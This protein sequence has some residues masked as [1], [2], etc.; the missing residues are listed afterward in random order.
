MDGLVKFQIHFRQRYF[1]TIIAPKLLDYYNKKISY[2]EYK[3][4][5]CFKQRCINCG[6]WYVTT[7]L[8]LCLNCKS[9]RCLDCPNEKC[10]YGTM[11]VVDTWGQRALCYDNH[12]V[13]FV[14]KIVRWYKRKYFK[15]HTIPNL[16]LLY[17]NEMKIKYHPNNIHKFIHF[18]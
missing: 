3:K 9:R 13:P 18:N 11:L 12:K 14:Y 15:N 10:C 7:L 16:W 5:N 8:I 2:D 4:I 6:S 17:E 1:K